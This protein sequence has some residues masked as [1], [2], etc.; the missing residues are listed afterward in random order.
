LPNSVQEAIRDRCGD[1]NVW[2]EGAQFFVVLPSSCSLQL[3]PIEAARAAV[4]LRAHPELV[5]ELNWHLAKVA[6]YLSS[7]DGLEG[8]FRA[9]D[10]SFTKRS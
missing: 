7:I 5:N 8:Q 4:L 2:H 6:N 3:S 10:R 1:R 9:L